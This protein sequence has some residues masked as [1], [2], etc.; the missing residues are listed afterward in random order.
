MSSFDFRMNGGNKGYTQKCLY[1]TAS[2]T[3]IGESCGKRSRMR[4]VDAA[5]APGKE[6]DGHK[7]GDLKWGRPRE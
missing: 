4:S 3:H 7:D 5:Q 1:S 2:P 6:C